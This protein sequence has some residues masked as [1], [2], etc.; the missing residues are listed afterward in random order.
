MGTVPLRNIFLAITFTVIAFSLAC[1]DV[2]ATDP[3]AES[4]D[5]FK[6]VWQKRLDNAVGDHAC[7]E[8]PYQMNPEH[9]T[10]PVIDSHFH[11]PWLP[12]AE[13]VEGELISPYLDAVGHERFDVK[14]PVLGVNR[15]MDE[16]ACTLIRERTAAVFAFFPVF[17]HVPEMS[18]EVVKRTED[19]YPDLF[20]PFINPPGRGTA[21]VEN[22]ELVE[23]LSIRPGLFDGYGEIPLYSDGS[24]GDFGLPPDSAIFDDI[25][26][27][28]NRENLAVYFHAGTEQIES[29]SKTLAANPDVNFIVHG[30]QIEFDITQL[31]EKHD[32]IY[33]TLNDLYGDQYLLHQGETTESFVEKVSNFE[34]LLQK[35]LETW[36]EAIET[37]PDQFMW[38]TDRGGIAVWTFDYEVGRVLNEYARAFI[39]RLDPE[40]QDR[41]AYQNALRAMKQD[42]ASWPPVE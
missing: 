31:M 2:G 22:D 30:E 25:Y 9:Y 17:L 29:F 16:I 26:D 24:P 7:D 4:D 11:I 19:R 3:G 14:F 32:N 8:P 20:F 35:D 27:T 38:G 33:F 41:F 42:T 37:Y 12:D 36:E 40:V 23:M 21:T 15:S 13:P 10:G 39:A 18:V 34:P 1:G 6:K 28:L 5:L